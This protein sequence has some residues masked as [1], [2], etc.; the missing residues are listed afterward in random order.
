MRKLKNMLW[1]IMAIAVVVFVAISF[2]KDDVKEYEDTNGP[3]DYSLTT[4]TDQQII[5]QSIG[6]LN[7]TRKNSLIGDSVVFSSDNFNGVYEIMYNNYIFATGVD[8]S[9][10]TFN[11]NKGNFKM[12][13]VQDD[14]IIETIEPGELSTDIHLEDLSGTVALRIAGE[15]ADFEF[16]LSEY[17]YDQFNHD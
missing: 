8:F 17:D 4:I 5:D 14:K 15:S 1:I 12:V 11:V 2:I 9:V 6:A 13:V 3:D 7:V 16:T 10:C